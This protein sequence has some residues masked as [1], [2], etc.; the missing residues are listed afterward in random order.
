[1]STRRSSPAS[2]SNGPES[3]AET[4]KVKLARFAADDDPITLAEACDLVFRGTITEA[5][6]R[7]E[8]RRGTLD[9]FKIGRRTFTTINDLREMQ[10][11]CRVTR[12]APASISTGDAN[13]GSLETELP[14]PA[15][16][17]LNQTCRR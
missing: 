2:T 17:A 15:L 13:N 8:E 12:K 5:S 3:A 11:K 14:S 9:T 7:A 1:M 16:V 6:L 10:R 4:R